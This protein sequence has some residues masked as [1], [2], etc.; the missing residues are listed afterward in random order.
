MD[1]GDIVLVFF[2]FTDLSS[3]KQRLAFHPRALH[4]FSC[5]TG[6]RDREPEH[7]TEFAAGVIETGQ[8]SGCGSRHVSVSSDDRSSGPIG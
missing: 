8:A 7:N 2:P 4:V 6:F 5:Y 1:G 3:S